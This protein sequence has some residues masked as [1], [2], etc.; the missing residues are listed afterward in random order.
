MRISTNTWSSVNLKSITGTLII[1]VVIVAF[2]VTGFGGRLGRNFDSNVAATVGSQEVSLRSL[3]EMVQQYERQSGAQDASQRNAHVQAALNQLVQSKVFLEESSELGW[4]AT[5]MEIAQWIRSLPVFKDEKTKKYKPELH[6]RFIK[7]GQMTEL[8]LK[9]A[10]KD[11]I[12]QQKMQSLL[13]LPVVMPTKLLKEEQTRDSQSFELEYVE[14]RPSEQLLKAKEMEQA[15]AFVADKNNAKKL[16]ES[17]EKSKG[18]FSHKAQINL[19]GILIGWKDAQ[20]AQ[21]DS[22]KRSKDEAKAIME[23]IKAKLDK[24]EIFTKVA[25]QVNDDAA[26]KAKAGNMGW[27]DDTQVDP[28]TYS[29]AKK[30]SKTKPISDIIETP[31]GYRMVQFLDERPEK[32]ATFDEVKLELARRIVSSELRQKL[33]LDVQADFAKVISDKD[34]AA[35]IPALI[36]KHGLTWKKIEKPVTANEKFIEGVGSSDSL[37]ANLFSL[38]KPG[39]M[40]KNI[41]NI[42]GKSYLFR[43]I[44][45][46]VVSPNV[47]LKQAQSTAQAIFARNFQSDSE[48]KLYEVYL[49]E[50]KIRINPALQN[51]E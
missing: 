16:E 15:N 38:K 5:D 4:G 24:G 21:G 26:A 41:V 28:A 36:T 3:N 29:A 42:S 11:S 14:L 8:E 51:M 43:L 46:K 39:D 50:K 34:A 20:R 40:T 7:N 25:M 22:L 45:R 48:K 32:N 1:T 33:G 44:N 23:S 18:E 47:D 31:Y 37:L 12:S 9:D 10:G 35:K 27:L 2:A 6:A 17:W 49:K 30:L 19:N 13:M